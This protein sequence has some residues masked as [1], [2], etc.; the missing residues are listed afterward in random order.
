MRLNGNQI[1]SLNVMFNDENMWHF[2]ILG[3]DPLDNRVVKV[4]AWDF[5]YTK[6]KRVSIDENGTI[7]EETS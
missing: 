4:S 2:D 6:N 5:E 7:F 1:D 3:A